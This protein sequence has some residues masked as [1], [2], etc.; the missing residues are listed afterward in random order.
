[1]CLL[2]C[3]PTRD[4]LPLLRRHPTLYHRAVQQALPNHVFDYLQ[5]NPVGVRHDISPL[6]LPQAASFKPQSFLCWLSPVSLVGGRFH[7]IF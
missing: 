1:M 4:L 6:T 5:I 3:L 7:G 2:W